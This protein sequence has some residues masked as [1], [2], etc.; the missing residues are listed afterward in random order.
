MSDL[1]LN[2]MRAEF[3]KLRDSAVY[4]MGREE[5]D[6]ILN[7][8]IRAGATPE[9]YLAVAAGVT[10]ECERCQGTGRYSWGA[11]VNGKMSHTGDCFRCSG[12]GYQDQD[13]FR[14]N[15]AYDRHAIARAMSA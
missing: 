8:S 11:S 2:E 7:A 5:F 14:R 15:R 4:A 6:S 1:N 12:K 3:K 10:C 13:D 9:E